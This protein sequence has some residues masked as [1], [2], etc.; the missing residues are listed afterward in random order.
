MS[1]GIMG[2]DDDRPESKNL[3]IIVTDAMGEQTL[4]ACAASGYAYN[5]TMN[6]DDRSVRQQFRNRRATVWWFNNPPYGKTAMQIAIDGKLVFPY[7]AYKAAQEKWNHR[8]A[9]FLGLVPHCKLLAL[10]LFF[11]LVALFY[12]LMGRRRYVHP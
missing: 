5:G 1:T 4:I 6:C 7:G 3:N 11:P 9:H 10:C 12:F 2:F 8:N